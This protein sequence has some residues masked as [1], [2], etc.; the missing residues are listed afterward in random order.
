MTMVVAKYLLTLSK[1][2]TQMVNGKRYVVVVDEILDLQLIN[3]K[4]Y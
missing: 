2:R 3:F 4:L 1:R